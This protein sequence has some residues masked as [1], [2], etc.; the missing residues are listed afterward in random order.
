MDR[1]SMIFAMILDGPVDPSAEAR[2]LSSIALAQSDLNTSGRVGATLRF[3]GIVR[4]DEPTPGAPA[5][6]TPPIRSL[7]A[8][9]YQ[10]YDPMAQAQLASLAHGIAREFGLLAL[11]TLHSR[12]RVRVGE[13]S[14]VLT[15]SSAHRA[16]ALTAMMAFIDRMKRDVPIWKTPVWAD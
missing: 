10:S 8:L 2:A 7:S 14:F 9:Q 16:E 15:I 12:G 6:E 3:E 11:T 1:S 13:I 4:R 5:G